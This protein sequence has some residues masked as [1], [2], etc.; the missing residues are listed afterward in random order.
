M[1]LTSLLLFPL[2]LA[3]G[4]TVRSA[5]A[6]TFNY[7]YLFDSGL[8]VTGSFTG[9][10]NGDFVDNVADV[11]LFYDGVAVSG[12]LFT[13]SF[14]GAAFQSGPLIS[15]NPY[16]SNF[17]F[18]NTDLAAGDGYDSVF[19]ILNSSVYGDD[20]ALAYSATLGAQGLGQPPSA[21]SLVAASGPVPVGVPERA[22][23]F[24]LFGLGLI[25]LAALRRTCVV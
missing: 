12:P 1:K 6:D 21:W 25:A 3:L 23:T 2:A 22:A 13:S 10:A 11:T 19:Y 17:A 9:T 7:S 24:G 4:L 16:L 14:D 8:L 20:I 5:S 18:A 15:F